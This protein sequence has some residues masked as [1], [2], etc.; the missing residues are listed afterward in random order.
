MRDFFIAILSNQKNKTERKVTKWIG[1]TFGYPNG[2][3][4]NNDD[5]EDDDAGDGCRE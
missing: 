5:D 4:D 1:L 3:D 2:W